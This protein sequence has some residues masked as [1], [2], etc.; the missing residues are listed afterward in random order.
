MR[1]S[2]AS[3][4]RPAH[5]A[6]ASTATGSTA[7]ARSGR[8]GRRCMAVNYEGRRF[9]DEHQAQSLAKWIGGIVYTGN[10]HG[11]TKPPW[12][13]HTCVMPPE[14]T[15]GKIPA[16]T[17]DWIIRGTDGSVRVEAGGNQDGYCTD[18]GLPV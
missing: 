15:E 9:G 18:C 1:W 10:Q 11:H 8:G 12:V 4:P 17:G 5:S 16:E 14:N 6:A 2:T 3:W 13:Q 7:S